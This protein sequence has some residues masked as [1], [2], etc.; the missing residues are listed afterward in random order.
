[1]SS[2]AV[3]DRQYRRI[4][5]TGFGASIAIHGAILGFSTFEAGPLGN[6]PAEADVRER[7]AD[8]EIP[9]LELIS[10]ERETSVA[11]EPVFVPEPAGGAERIAENPTPSAA[12]PEARMEMQLALSM[13]PDFYSTRAVSDW[14]LQPISVGDAL[15]GGD[16]SDE[17]DT[18]HDSESGG[19]SWW[20][21]LGISIGG[22]SG[23]HCPVDDR[24]PAVIMG[25]PVT[26][27]GVPN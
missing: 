1:M 8:F 12:T 19:K 24:A 17:N 7:S 3:R 20:Q 15:M 22:G 9:A 16:D 2:R 11:V 21:R 5:T 13:R 18:G 6:E 4:L 27:D 14:A 23:G 10:L 26:G 25:M